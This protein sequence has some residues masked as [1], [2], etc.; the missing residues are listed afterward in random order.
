[1]RSAAVTVRLP[2]ARTAPT[3]NNNARA[4][5]GRVNRSAKQASRDIMASGSEDGA[6]D[7]GI[8]WDCF[9]PSVESSFAATASL[10]G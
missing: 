6:Q 1:M 9:I 5:V 10:G 7:F 8:A 2:G 4:H 3:I